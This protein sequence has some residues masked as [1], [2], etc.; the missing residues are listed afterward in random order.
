MNSRTRLVH[1]KF[2]FLIVVFCCS[3]LEHTLARAWTRWDEQLP[4]LGPG[5][6]APMG[7]VRGQTTIAVRLR[8]RHAGT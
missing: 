5:A 4:R 3:P 7:R 2:G 6:I 1:N 8:R